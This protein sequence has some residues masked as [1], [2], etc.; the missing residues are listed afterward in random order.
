MKYAIFQE[1]PPDVDETWTHG[2]M[3]GGMIG[4]ADEDLAESYFLA[5]DT[6]I[7]AILK[8]DATGH[9]LVNP[10]MYVYRHG[11]ELYLKCIVHPS[12]RSHSLGSLLD[13]F[14]RHVR[15]GYGETVPP[16]I[17]KPITE[18]AMYD[19]RSDVFRYETNKDGKNHEPIGQQGEFWIDLP[20]LKASMA[21]LRRSFRRVL[22]AERAGGE[23]PPRGVG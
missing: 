9:D 17:T 3:L 16:V 14:C 22:W 23:I 19:Q 1:P 20:S 2:A 11:I 8:G 7:A 5:G 15:E 13:A 12:N 10:V 4:Y 18:F 21:L 6:L